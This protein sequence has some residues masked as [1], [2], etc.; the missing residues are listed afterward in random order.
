MALR[1]WVKV[2]PWIPT[3]SASSRWLPSRWVFSEIRTNQM[4]S[5]PPAAASASSKAPLTV[6]AVRASFRPIGG[7]AGGGIDRQ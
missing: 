7:R 1:W 6:F 4:G 5:D 3:A 2:A